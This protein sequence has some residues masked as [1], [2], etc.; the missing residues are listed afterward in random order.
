MNS[1]INRLGNFVYGI[2]EG[3]Q[4][5]CF[6][7]SQGYPLSGVP[8]GYDN[9]TEGSRGFIRGIDCQAAGS[10]QSAEFLPIIES[11]RVHN[12]R[13]H[14]GTQPLFLSAEKNC[15][16]PNPHTATPTLSRRIEPEV[17]FLASMV[18][19]VSQSGLIAVV[20]CL[21]GFLDRQAP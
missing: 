8:A 13:G 17:C 3:E 20:V 5:S 10:D 19:F 2:V 21:V 14:G 4:E 18:R 15:N 1:G 16:G 7:Y 11:L 12:Q 6:V 9:P